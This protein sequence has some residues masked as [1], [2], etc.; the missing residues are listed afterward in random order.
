MPRRQGP[1][2]SSLNILLPYFINQISQK[3]AE[4]KKAKLLQQN[5]S[6]YN[7]W[8]AG[9]QTMP[10]TGQ[11]IIP[12]E[13][14]SPV[15]NLSAAFNQFADQNYK[16]AE[17][18]LVSNDVVPYEAV[19]KRKDEQAKTQAFQ[20]TWT[21]L[22]DDLKKTLTPMLP[23]FQNDPAELN[24]YVYAYQKDQVA[25]QDKA[26]ALAQIEPMEKQPGFSPLNVNYL[27][28]LGK[29]V[30]EGKVL[31]YAKMRNPGAFPKTTADMSPI[32]Q[33]IQ[34]VNDITKGKSFE[35][36]TQK[37]IQGLRASGMSY[38]EI[39]QSYGIEGV[40]PSL[41]VATERSVQASVEGFGSN[42]TS[43]Q[44]WLIAQVDSTK[45]GLKF[46]NEGKQILDPEKAAVDNKLWP[47][48][49]QQFNLDGT[50]KAGYVAKKAKAL[51]GM[52][53]LSPQ[54][55]LVADQYGQ[56]I[57]GGADAAGQAEQFKA[58]WEKSLAKKTG[59][60]D[61]RAVNEIYNY[62]KGI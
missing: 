56:R 61:E 3:N 13:G 2:S 32:E 41:K 28:L 30:P 45:A 23:T 7:T 21:A 42:A 53:N 8:M 26:D 48:F 50:P 49:S 6:A 25:Q 11:G 35:Q 24:R 31:E 59:G 27:S 33:K 43:F 36:L 10:D 54:Q 16:N 52:Q 47:N 19:Q 60:L 34:V 29:V 39:K 46:D 58:D 62:L 1:I 22:P 12:P 40:P 51:M 9:P 20:Q 44:R 5:I 4:D 17:A 37:D 18:T 14:G 57:L 15:G 38:D 55:R